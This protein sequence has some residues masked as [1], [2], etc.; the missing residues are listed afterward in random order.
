M[1]VQNLRVN[2]VY[3]VTNEGAYVY[4]DI[5]KNVFLSIFSDELLMSFFMMNVKAQ[6]NAFSGPIENSLKEY[7]SVKIL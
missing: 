2:K 1:H 6:H 5:D 4:T 7:K 3:I